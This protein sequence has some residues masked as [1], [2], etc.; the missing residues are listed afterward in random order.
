[1]RSY[2]ISLVAFFSTSSIFTAPYA[3]LSNLSCRR[4]KDIFD[5]ERRRFLENSEIEAIDLTE[6][7]LEKF[8]KGFIGNERIGL[9]SSIGMGVSTN[10]QISTT[11]LLVGVSP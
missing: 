10:E 3:F 7:T 2:V 6:A 4:F 9:V 8:P 5:R 11:N 1:M